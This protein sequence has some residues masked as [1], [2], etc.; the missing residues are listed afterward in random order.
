LNRRAVHLDPLNAAS[1]EGLAETEFF[2]GQLDQAA[3]DSKKA[4]ELSPHVFSAPMKLSAIYVVQGRPQDALPEIELVRYGPSRAALYA[5]AYY[6][7]GRKKESDAALSELI[8]KYHTS[9]PYQIAQVYAYRNQPDEAFE[10]LDR[11][12]A[13]RDDGLIATKVA[14]P[15]EELAQGPAIF[16][17]LEAAQSAELKFI[18]M[19]TISGMREPQ[20]P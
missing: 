3:A 12:F 16:S 18:A 10:L 11:A 5:I 1:W 13:Q 19:G 8:T 6:A 15:T 17:A 14:P 4:L 2:M 9:N 20:I 7:F